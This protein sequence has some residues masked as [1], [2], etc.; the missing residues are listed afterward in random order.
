MKGGDYMMLIKRAYNASLGAPLKWIALACLQPA[1][2]QRE[3]E[4][5]NFRQRV[6]MQTRLLVPLFLL[7]LL[8]VT[9]LRALPLPAPLFVWS[10]EPHG[11]PANPQLVS[12]IGVA[13]GL[14]VGLVFG[15]VRGVFFG[16]VVGLTAGVVFGLPG[17]YGLLHTDALGAWL[18]PALGL[19]AGLALSLS[20]GLGWG[21]TFGIIIGLAAAVGIAGP[22]II[23]DLILGLGFSLALNV[24]GGILSRL[25]IS[26]IVG[27]ILGVIGG[28]TAGLP[29][30]LVGGLAAGLGSILGL[31]ACSR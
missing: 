15:L 7:S 28:F 8:F 29:G 13:F 27:V 12:T 5:T 9:L 22:D 31:S 25:E 18:I 1:R 21:L 3:Y 20:F 11:L 14:V 24:R 17:V 10:I 23:A 30:G 26:L 16:I 2:F 6:G 19:A 4:P